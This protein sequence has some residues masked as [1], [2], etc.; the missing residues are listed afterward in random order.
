MDEKGKGLSGIISGNMDVEAAQAFLNTLSKDET[1]QLM[2]DGDLASLFPG[3]RKRNNVRAHPSPSVSR[4]EI[5][6]IW[7]RIMDAA[8]ERKKG[9]FFFRCGEALKRF[10]GACFPVLPRTR[11]VKTAM[12]LCVTLFFLTI[13]VVVERQYQAGRDTLWVKGE[14]S[15]PWPFA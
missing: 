13:T 1:S 14:N 10:V 7:C 8:E 11:S 12:A 4:E 5:D 9:A 6:R 2:A 3:Y 15:A